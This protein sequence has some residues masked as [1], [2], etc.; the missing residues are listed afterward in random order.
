MIMGDQDDI[1]G[2]KVL[3]PEAGRHHA[4]G[5]GEGYWTR[6]LRPMRRRA[7]FVGAHFFTTT[8]L[9]S[10][11]AQHKQSSGPKRHDRETSLFSLTLCPR[12]PAGAV[13]VRSCIYKTYN[14]AGSSGRN[15]DGIPRR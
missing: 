6:S 2:R 1:N 11:E 9:N 4:V 7:G 15:P 8:N 3:K 14:G 10:Q 13:P 5:S 12:V